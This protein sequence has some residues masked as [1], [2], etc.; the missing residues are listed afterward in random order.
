MDATLVVARGEGE[1]FSV[2]E[3]IEG[4]HGG[5]RRL[6]KWCYGNVLSSVWIEEEKREC[7]CGGFNFGV[8]NSARISRWS[9]IQTSGR[10]RGL[11]V[12][13]SPV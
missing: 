9:E 4:Y 3:G 5:F 2:W 12:G 13:E 6:K 10:T 11:P 1:L 8:L 7:Y